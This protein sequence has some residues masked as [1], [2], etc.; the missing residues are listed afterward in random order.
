MIAEPAGA[1][2]E[3]SSGLNGT[4]RSTSPVISCILTL[5]SRFF[6]L[7]AAGRESARG[8]LPWRQRRLGRRFR[9]AQARGSVLRG[10]RGPSRAGDGRGHRGARR[11]AGL[12]AKN[13]RIG[14]RAGRGLL[15]KTCSPRG[16]AGAGLHGERPA[17]GVG[18]FGDARAPV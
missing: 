18:G 10:P 2:A 4:L 3:G 1:G 8:T 9:W 16:R 13:A 5:A 11:G 6:S 7:C 15:A 14:G 17:D 12:L